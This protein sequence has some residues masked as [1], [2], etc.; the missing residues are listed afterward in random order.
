MLY[1][2]LHAGLSSFLGEISVDMLIIGGGII[3][4]L[5]ARE[6]RLAGAE[7]TVIERVNTGRE[8]SWA[9]GGI[10]SPLYPW[11]YDPSITHLAAWSQAHYRQL[12]E[13]LAEETGID[14]E[15]T[16]SGLL[17]LSPA[18]EKA[19]HEWGERFGNR[20]EIID[21][22]ELSDCEPALAKPAE[23]AI[24]MSEVAQVRN[25]RLVRALRKNIEQLGVPIIEHNRVRKIVFEKDRVSGVL[26]G[27]EKLAVKRLVIC[28]GA[29]TGQLLSGILNP[30][31]IEPVLGQMILFRAR[32]GL[33][34]RIT[35]E[36]DRYIIPR[37]DGRVLFGSTL[38]YTG[39]EKRT[40][41][42]VRDKLHDI[43]VSRFPVL[44]PFPIEHHWAGLRPFSPKG[45]P[46]LGQHPIV[47]GLYV[48]AGHFR[49]GVVLGPASA[50]L[51]AD[52]ILGR[53]PIVSPD[54][55]GFAV[56]R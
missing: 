12:S 4:M 29:W 15:W 18:E 36:Q 9:G 43:A 21:R 56:E 5:T 8:S 44:K 26:T 31:Q 38:E 49:N 11:R 27:A 55:Y 37:R 34:S 22:Q 47:E 23:S 1:S 35:L 41:V 7:V 48:N 2:K 39:F 17:L 16:K 52:I 25:P 6:L 14:P 32:P 10:I 50:R 40:T 19:A 46:Y 42:S 53:R 45:I 28:A 33:V 20:V 3:G 13:T 30:P 24:W 51:I 54:P